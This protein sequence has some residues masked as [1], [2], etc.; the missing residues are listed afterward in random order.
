[1]ASGEMNCADFTAFLER[2]CQNL[3]YYSVNGSIHFVCMDWRH[4]PELSIAEQAAFSELKNGTAPHINTFELV[5][6]GK[7]RT[8]V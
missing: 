3:A 2:V 1:M 7:Y 5:Q 4:L 6:H 8:N